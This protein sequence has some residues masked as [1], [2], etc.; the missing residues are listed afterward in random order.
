MNIQGNRPVP[1][2]PLLF[3]FAS[4]WWLSCHG[5]FSRNSYVQ[6]LVMPLRLPQSTS[7]R[8]RL[9]VQT[10]NEETSSPPKKKASVNKQKKPPRFTQQAHKSTKLKINKKKGGTDFDSSDSPSQGNPSKR[11]ASSREPWESG[12][13]IEDLENI[14]TNRWGTMNP[15]QGGNNSKGSKKKGNLASNTKSKRWNNNNV[16]KDGSFV[17]NFDNNDGD[18]WEIDD[19]EDDEGFSKS[20]RAV[21]DPW[22]KEELKARE[23]KKK[24]RKQNVVNRNSVDREYYDHD[25]EGYEYDESNRES[26][27]SGGGIGVSHVISPKP[28]GGRG[29]I[30]RQSRQREFYDD[31]DIGRESGG[32]GSGYFFNSNAA[33][34]GP[35]ADDT[36]KKKKSQPTARE[37]VQEGPTTTGSTKAKPAKRV[38]APPSKPMLDANGQPLLLTV[39][40]ATRQFKQLS[41]APIND[42]I[43]A[44]VTDEGSDEDDEGDNFL[45]E[46]DDS[47]LPFDSEESASMMIADSTWSDLGITAPLLSDNLNFMG[48]PTPLDVQDK[49]CPPILTGQDVLVGTYTGSGKTLAFLVPLVQKLLWDMDAGSMKPDNQG[50]SILIVAPGRE[51]ASQIT[52]VARSLIQDTN[53][54]VLMAIGGTTFSRNTEQIRKQK[55]TILVGTPGRIAELVVGKPGERYVVIETCPFCGD[56][57]IPYS[58]KSI[59]C[60][61]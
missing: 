14:M 58:C 32:G 60:L 28:V 21:L 47:S 51:L 5:I 27:S 42:G 57:R 26:Q 39:D 48:C 16:D 4:V 35:A 6:G 54:S 20:R 43:D 49:A 11:G 19:G 25:D 33:S 56:P 3:M 13:S 53:L 8:F 1:M 9:F 44:K 36:R 30:N 37:V 10:G 31:D 40:E 61:H 34:K 12:K 24:A 59:N 15:Q 50:P 2:R 38:A 46:D 29:T 52:S 41:S 7:R 17:F 22:Q 45:I 55:P 23:D 18:D